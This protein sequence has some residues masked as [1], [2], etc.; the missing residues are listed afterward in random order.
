MNGIGRCSEIYA[1]SHHDGIR[2]ARAQ[3]ERLL[4]EHAGIVGRSPSAMRR[5]ESDRRDL[6]QEIAL[7]LW[8]LTRVTR[9][10]A[11][12]QLGCTHRSKRFDFFVAQETRDLVARRC[13]SMS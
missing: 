13:L 10:T 2:L 1:S 9:Q 4:E 6:M 7:Q 11:H 3:F 8:R 5:T 12:F